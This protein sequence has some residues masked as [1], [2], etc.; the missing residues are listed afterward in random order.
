MTWLTKERNPMIYKVY[1]TNGARQTYDIDYFESDGSGV[2]LWK[3]DGTLIAFYYP[4]QV[5]QIFP[6]QADEPAEVV[7]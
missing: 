2:T 6:E 4:G 1:T 5:A 3:N 7:T